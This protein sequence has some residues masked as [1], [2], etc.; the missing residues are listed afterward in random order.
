M[1]TYSRVFG[2]SIFS[3]GM[4][5]GQETQDGSRYFEYP[6]AMPG[7]VIK[8]K[9]VLN[10]VTGRMEAQVILEGSPSSLSLDALAESETAI[11]HAQRGPFSE[12]LAEKIPGMGQQSRAQVIVHLKYPPIS[13]PDKTVAST[14]ELRAS[15]IAAAALA[16][17]SSLESLFQRHGILG[18]ETRGNSVAE[19]ELTR[20]QLES[21]KQDPDV[22]AMDLIHEETRMSPDLLTLN[23]SAYNPG[24]VPSGAGSG[25]HAATFET[26]LTS[27]FLSCIGVTPVA[28]DANVSSDAWEIRHANGVFR[29]LIATAPSASFY[30]RLSVTYDGSNDVNYLIN[31]GIQTVNMS[32]TRGGTSPYHA[33]NSEFLVMDDF[34]Y[35]YPYP[36]YVNGSG[37]A[38]Y[39]YEVNWQG[40]NGIS[41]GDVR[42]TNNSTYELADCTQTKN[43]PPVYGS[44]ISGS[45]AN[46]AGD[47]EMPH[48]V[49]PGTPYTG[50]DFA[51]TCLAGSG[52]V[53]CGTSWSAGVG[54]GIAADVIAADSRLAGW[55]EKVRATM[56]LTAQNVDGGD[57]TS[58]TDG[59]DGSGVVSGSEAVSFAQNHTTVA[60]SGSAVE[61]GMMAASM[62][63]ADFSAGNK[64]FNYLVP[65][66]KPSGKHLRAVLTWDSNPVVG[67]SINA[68]S[69]LDLIVQY[70]GSTRYSSSWDNNVEVV[71]IAA[72][73]LTAGSSY[74]IDVAPYSNRI[75][76]SGSRTN[77]FYYAIAWTWVKDHAN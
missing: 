56:I 15:S 59:R 74:Y 22:A 31:N 17:I 33:T 32:L 34:A 77:Y 67:G 38:G 49:V 28:Y 61:K 25:V 52:T 26:G 48:V 40:Y 73:E 4:I 20:S 1:K 16:P 18:M 42:H 24:G 51:S 47:R 10:S 39:S 7:R 68:L 37:N 23:S 50:T 63:A 30:H 14:E 53:A 69:D 11:V 60:V 75:P 12:E 57:W 35:R 64:R 44:C 45:G 62:Y 13:Y 55:P 36:V 29:C 72:S 66:P 58:G 21:L 76:A 54:N 43:P 8:A 9:K 65:N 41:V 5:W 70:N 46:C 6:H 71:D 27:G 2:I 19:G 3:M